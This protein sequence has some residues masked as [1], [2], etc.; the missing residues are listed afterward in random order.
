[1]ASPQAQTEI[2]K[3]RQERMHHAYRTKSRWHIITAT[4][5][6]NAGLFF[7][8]SRWSKPAAPKLAVVIVVDQMRYDYL[9][10][11]A[12][13]FTGG[14][15]K[16]L[17]EGAVFTNAHHDH[18]GT[19][20][21]PGHATLLTG[22]FP[23]HHGIVGNTWHDRQTM[24]SLY[25]VDDRNSSLVASSIEASS[26]IGKS[27]R[28]LL[29]HTLGDWLKAKYADAKVVSIA[30]KDRSAILMAGWDADAAYWFHN[31]SGSFVSSRYYLKALPNWAAQWNAAR[32]ADRYFGKLWEKLRPEEDYFVSRE[33]WFD[34]EGDG[35]H[36]TFPHAFV[37]DDESVADSA[38]SRIDA[39][40]YGWL[41]NTPFI[42]VLTLEFAQ[43]A[44]ES[45]ALGADAT[46][47]LLLIGL[48]AMDAVGHAY[49]PLSQESEDNLLRLDAELE[50]FFAVLE[51][52]V[53]MKN[54][55]IALSADHGVL[56]LPEELR[57]RGFESARILSA[58]ALDEVKS[59]EKEMQE[60]WRTKRSILRT[61][62]GDLNLDYRAADS[63]GL[64]PAEFRARV[65]AKLRSLSFVG[66][67][68]TS[69]ELSAVDGAARD[70]LDKQRRSF[71]PDRSPDLTMQLK[72]HYLVTS[73]P[74]GT[75]HGSPY[76]YDTH[77]P[78]IF[79]GERIKP[80]RIDAPHRTVDLAPT[81]A[82]LLNLDAPRLA[83]I[84][85]QKE[86]RSSAPI[87]SGMDGKVLMMAIKK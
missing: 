43:Q 32:R 9:V 27:P 36:T 4:A 77:V 71:H 5:V 56:P 82:Y 73:N 10:R 45:E 57:R 53:R 70:Y 74:H 41:A 81:L 44:I 40:F 67:I 26:G 75:T 38:Q 30:A 46:P 1:M 54:C 19:E 65:A 24:Q 31:A 64:P 62:L 16:L 58:E 21:A 63:L 68:F 29:R 39:R 6:L 60:E 17:R 59:V 72:P 83:L 33:D 51:A 80:Q 69:D 12:G 52:K 14:F 84:K 11:F 25:C 86:G 15:A 34:A 37:N 2:Q 79:W 7:S 76:E 55:V 22:S 78:L 3:L 48:K 42:D 8:C 13:L 66:D 87:V 61:Y 50:K 47:D 20:T 23:S 85:S 35:E 49:G 18:A 28:N